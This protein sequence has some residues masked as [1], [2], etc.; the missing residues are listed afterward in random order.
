[1]PNLA[2]IAALA[3]SLSLVVVPA[4]A[5]IGAPE[6]IDGPL[7]E[8]WRAPFE[9]FLRELKVEDQAA[10][11]AKTSAFQIGGIWRPDSILFRIEDPGVCSG[12]L[13]FVVI[14]RVIENKLV[15]DAM[16]AAGKRFTRSDRFLP[17]F[18]FKTVPA[19]FGG[20]KISVTLVEAPNGWIITA[21]PTQTGASPE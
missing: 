18:G 12:D 21:S 1:M 15:A 7:K 5:Q 8:E 20:D 13:C 9:M 14:G 4:G 16:F 17:L 6:L 10:L 11:V 2:N 19:W 3:I